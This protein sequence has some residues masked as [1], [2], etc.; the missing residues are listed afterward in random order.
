[1]SGATWQRPPCLAALDITAIV[2]V[3]PVRVVA[4]VDPVVD[5]LGHSP[6]SLYAETYWLPILG[7]SALLALRRLDR[8]LDDAPDGFALH[9]AAF[10]AE[11][12]ISPATTVRTI[13]RLIH[14]RLAA[15]HGRQLAVARKVPPLARRHIER[16]PAHLAALHGHPHPDQEVNP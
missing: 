16:L 14:F 5:R 8:G 9:V 11:L 1:V 3:E 7:P 15:G 13:G 2:A 4:M 6:A 12:G 10:G